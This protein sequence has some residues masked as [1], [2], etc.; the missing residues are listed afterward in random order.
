MINT[1]ISDKLIK[2]EHNSPNLNPANDYHFTRGLSNWVDSQVPPRK[3]KI[4]ESMADT[5]ICQLLEAAEVGDNGVWLERKPREKGTRSEHVFNI[6]HSK[7]G[8][9]G[10]LLGN[11][12]P[13]TNTF[14]I[15][16]ISADSEDGGVSVAAIKSGLS[17]LRKH[18]PDLKVIEGD[19]R[20]SGTHALNSLRTGKPADTR[21]KIP[22]A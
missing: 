11:H 21:I 12:N 8:V 3:K 10:I 18:F 15:H 1:I 2:V 17:S 5:L 9:I 6:H 7:R 4:K 20:I 19:N 13:E 14:R 22:R 16:Y